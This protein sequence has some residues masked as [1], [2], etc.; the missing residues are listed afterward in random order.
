ME[1]LKNRIL[2]QGL[3]SVVIVS[4]SMCSTSV[5]SI[6]A[7]ASPPVSTTESS[8][9]LEDHKK[10]KVSNNTPGNP[11]SITSE[12]PPFV[13]SDPAVTVDTGEGIDGMTMLY[14]G[15]AVGLIAIGAVALGG[16]GGSSSGTDT[17]P[18]TPA[19]PVVG[20]DLNG[21]WAGF[22]EIKDV[23]APGYENITAT[24][25]QSGAAVQITTSSTLAYGRL[26]NGRI[27]SGGSM[28]MYDSITGQDWTTHYSK[29]T[30][31]NVDLYDYVNDHKDFDRMFLAR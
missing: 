30:T 5:I 12:E 1:S 28:K 14:I 29:A 7:Q 20:P 27:S 26:F 23:Q 11:T 31:T 10:E 15:G 17:S 13:A 24:I 6:A 2:K 3:V 8:V 16:G 18:E 19:T 22:L 25:V 4:L 9:L 21:N